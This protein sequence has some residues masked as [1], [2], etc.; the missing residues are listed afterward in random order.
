MLSSATS[1]SP[2]QVAFKKWLN[3]KITFTCLLLARPLSYPDRN[4]ICGSG[5]KLAHLEDDGNRRFFSSCQFPEKTLHYHISFSPYKPIPT[6]LGGA[7][8][9]GCK[10]ENFN[11]EVPDL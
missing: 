9:C 7:I 2:E 8:N 10:G 3:F 11:G 5:D 1:K 6:A 4:T